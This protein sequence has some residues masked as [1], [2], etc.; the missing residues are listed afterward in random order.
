VNYNP[1]SAVP[2]TLEPGAAVTE[3]GV[4]EVPKET[5]RLVLKLQFYDGEQR[6]S[7]LFVRLP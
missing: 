6:E 1:D 4:F 2:D 3:L 7:T 5:D